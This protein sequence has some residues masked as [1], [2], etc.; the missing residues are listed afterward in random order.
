MMAG[1]DDSLR[2]RLKCTSCRAFREF[3]R[4]GD[5]VVRCGE[6]GKRHSTDSLHAVTPDQEPDFER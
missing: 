1:R 6:C 3:E 2:I 4:E 5:A